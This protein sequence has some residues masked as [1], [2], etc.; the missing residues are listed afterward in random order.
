MRRR[1]AEGGAG[2]GAMSPCSPTPQGSG[3]LSPLAGGGV[4][5][6][7]P[8]LP[9]QGHRC[10]RGDAALRLCCF[11]SVQLAGAS[12]PLTI[13]IRYPGGTSQG[14]RLRKVAAVVGWVLD[15]LKSPESCSRARLGLRSLE[16]S[17]SA[18]VPG[19]GEAEPALPPGPRPAVRPGGQLPPPLSPAGIRRRGADPGRGASCEQSGW[20]MGQS[21][22]EAWCRAPASP[23]PERTR[24]CSVCG[25]SSVGRNCP[26]FGLYPSSR[27]RS[28]RSLWGTRSGTQ[29]ACGA[30]G[31]GAAVGWGHQAWRGKAPEALLG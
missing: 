6:E 31:G 3:G 28:I 27:E 25:A 26:H 11:R 9:G 7:C 8:Q 24:G 16:H 23:S 15:A 13:F 22:R 19:D 17:A 1:V 5:C 21:C 4:G 2:V 10:Q 29:V 18:A 20:K 14:S 30:V 12:L